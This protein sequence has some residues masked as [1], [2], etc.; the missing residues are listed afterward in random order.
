MTTV[1]RVM[2][3]VSQSQLKREKCINKI[4]FKE[5]KMTTKTIEIG[6][7]DEARTK[8]TTILSLSF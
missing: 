8:K 3:N 7:G 6:D 5:K 2:K 4:F 1:E